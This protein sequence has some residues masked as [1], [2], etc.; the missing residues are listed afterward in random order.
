M[1][2]TEQMR[3]VQERELSASISALQRAVRSLR[4]ETG[5]V[6]AALDGVERALD[7]ENGAVVVAPT[8]T[9]PPARPQLSPRPVAM[10]TDLGDR[11][12]EVTEAP[13]GHAQLWVPGLL[14]VL[15]LFASV[16]LL[17]VELA[18]AIP[19]VIAAAVLLQMKW[20]MPALAALALGLALAI[21]APGG[22]MTD[23][24]AAMCVVFVLTA[25]A[26][27]LYEVWSRLHS[28]LQA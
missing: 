4:D 22:P 17:E 16:A 28:R 9:A 3:E 2:G 1:I 8:E 21:S 19:V 24:V 14:C 5:R 27:L 7:R 23:N 12:Q 26:L 11:V 25:G 6:T 10:R 13:G 15:A 20:W 18:L